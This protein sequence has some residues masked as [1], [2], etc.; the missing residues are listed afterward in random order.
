ISP[1]AAAMEYQQITVQQHGGVRA[2]TLN[3]PVRLNTLTGRMIRELTYVFEE[4]AADDATNAVVLTGAGR[5]FC[6]GADLATGD[7]VSSSAEELGRTRRRGLDRLGR[8]GRLILALREREKPVIAA[9][10]GVAAGAGFGLMTACDLR[11]ASSEAR[12]STVFIRR[13]LAPDCGA[14]YFLPR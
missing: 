14:S 5:A 4:T 13:G 9:V 10:N 11:L 7:G 1:G 2:V 6:A 12:F 3:R 8:A